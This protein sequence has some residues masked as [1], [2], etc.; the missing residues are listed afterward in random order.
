MLVAQYS[1]SDCRFTLFFQSVGIF[2]GRI[3][4][5]VLP[6]VVE[7]TWRPAGAMY[8]WVGLTLDNCKKVD[9]AIMTDQ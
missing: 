5:E 8:T 2:K 1:E 7:K 3:L 9:K 4:F 6:V